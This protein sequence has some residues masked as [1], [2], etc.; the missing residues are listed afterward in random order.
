MIPQVVT[1]TK[2]I[3]R[4]I[5]KVEHG[6]GVSATPT[7]TVE[8]SEEI[9]VKPESQKRYALSHEAFKASLVS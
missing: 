3:V 6:V 2:E 9:G 5:V 1:R 8:V 7:V 4:A